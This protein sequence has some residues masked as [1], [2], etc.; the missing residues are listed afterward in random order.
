MAENLI[1]AAKL[2][3]T[4]R[5]NPGIDQALLMELDNEKCRDFSGMKILI[6]RIRPSLRSPKK[7]I[8]SFAI[9][10]AMAL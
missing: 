3:D 5:N 9:C 2:R 4:S 10:Q 8:Q 6:Y 7:T 1:S